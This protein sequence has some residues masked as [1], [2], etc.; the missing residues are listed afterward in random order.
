MDTP[1]AKVLAVD[2]ERATVSVDRA[3]ICARCAA[4]RG[5][6]AG[7]FG[8]RRQPAVIEVRLAAGVV[9]EAGD[10]VRLEFASAR[11]LHAAWLAYGLPLASM[12]GAVLLA[13]RIAPANELAAVLF[14]ACGLVAG[15]VY[16]R[17]L[18]LQSGCLSQCVPTASARISPHAGASHS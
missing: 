8:V 10:C 7:L 13:A 5:C 17:R 12:I 18:L 15:A 16:G 4:G 6:G 1:E 9:V 3:A 2:G 11:L 14:A